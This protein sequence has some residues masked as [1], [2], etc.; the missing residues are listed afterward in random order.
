MMS[1]PVRASMASR[2]AVVA[3]AA[4]SLSLGCAAEVGDDVVGDELAA[5]ST[6]DARSKW[7]ERH[8]ELYG[9][10]SYGASTP[11]I[12]FRKGEKRFKAFSFVGQAGDE[13]SARV[14]A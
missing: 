10:T 3:L 14:W 7:F 5:L 9:E 2:F 8:V 1:T 11:A 6:V 13:I 4:T 12:P